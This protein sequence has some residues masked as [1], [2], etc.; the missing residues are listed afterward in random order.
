MYERMLM[1]GAGLVWMGGGARAGLVIK[2]L[3]LGPA[4]ANSVSLW[5]L[6]GGEC[7]HTA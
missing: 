3:R 5:L 6:G 7:I 1:V 2:G 4:E